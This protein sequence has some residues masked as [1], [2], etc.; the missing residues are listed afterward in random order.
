MKKKLVAAAC[1]ILM[2]TGSHAGLCPPFNEMVVIGKLGVIEAALKVAWTTLFKALSGNL[3]SYDKRELSAMR[4]ATS[5]VATVAKAEINAAQALMAGKMAALGALEHTKQHLDVYQQFSVMT[6]QGVDPCAQLEAQVGLSEAGRRT[7][8]SIQRALMQAAAAPGRYSSPE[9]YIDQMLKIRQGTFLTKDEEAL[10]FGKASS[11]EVVTATGEKFPLA[12][13]DT[14]AAVLFADSN[15]ARVSAA[16]DAY[17][18]HIGGLPDLP[19][20]KEDA[21]LPAGKEYLVNKAQKDA[22]MSAALASIAAVAATNTPV[23]GKQSKTQA[24][25]ELVG[26]YF[27]KEASQRWKGWATQSSRGLLVD[28]LKIDAAALA[29]KAEQ[30]QDGQRQEVLLAAALLADVKTKYGNELESM[31]QNIDSIRAGSGVR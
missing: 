8:A 31:R 3:L 30:Y 21:A 6:G 17:L 19:I 25:R 9:S 7:N 10:G 16:K 28:Q 5:Q 23:D 22:V 11:A 24:M 1:A 27:G 13:A 18:N 12:G 2:S 14:N 4:V 20:K 26:Q 29:L 15:D